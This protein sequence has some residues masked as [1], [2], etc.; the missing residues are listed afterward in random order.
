MSSTI[1]MSLRLAGNLPPTDKLTYL[2]GVA[3]SQIFRKGDRISPKRSQPIDVCLL[4]L[5]K[6]DSDISPSESQQ[7]MLV[8]AKILDN[9]APAINCLDRSECQADLYISTVREDDQGGL[10]LPPALVAAAAAG[11][12][13]IQVS[14]LVMFDEDD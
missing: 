14:I 2:L 8:A 5:V 1:E 4:D 3:P 13:S 10:S 9:L 7:Q 6:F 12:L 11:N